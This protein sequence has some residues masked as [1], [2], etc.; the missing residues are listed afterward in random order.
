MNRRPTPWR[1]RE[2]GFTGPTRTLETLGGGWVA[3]VPT[4]LAYLFS[5]APELRKELR[6]LLSEVERGDVTETTIINARA[7]LTKADGGKL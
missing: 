5:A 4:E 6:I 7:A 3:S 1:V 2:E